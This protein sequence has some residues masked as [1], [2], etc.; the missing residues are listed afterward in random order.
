MNSAKPKF[1][2]CNNCHELPRQSSQKRSLR[3][4][5]YISSV[6]IAFCSSDAACGLQ[7]PECITV[8]MAV[9]QGERP[10]V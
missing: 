1:H 10:C 7:P 2:S 3:S 8:V 4:N 5:S 6:L 9:I